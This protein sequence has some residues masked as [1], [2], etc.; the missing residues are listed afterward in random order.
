MSD[1]K[2]EVAIHDLKRSKKDT[3][4]RY[5]EILR[6]LSAKERELVSALHIK[7]GVNPVTIASKRKRG[8]SQATVFVIMSDWHME[9]TV[10]RVSVNGLNAFN[11]RIAEERAMAV[12][13]N[14]VRLAEIVQKDIAVDKMVLA[15]IGDFISGNIHE[16]LLENCSLSPIDATIFAQ[17]IIAGGIKHIL[18]K[19]KL[20]IEV[21]TAAGNHAR[22]TK[23]T[24]F[25][26]ENGN[27]L[28]YM[29]Y[30]SLALHFARE[31]RV[32]FHISQGYHSFVCCYGRNIRFHHGHA[33]KYGGGIGGLTIPANKAIAQWNKGMPKKLV[34]DLDVFGH[35][36]TFIDA[37][38]FICN[39]SLIGYNAFAKAIK[40]SYEE[41]CQAFFVIDRD[42]GKTFVCPI[43]TW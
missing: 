20:D 28:E 31:K 37:G 9:E 25:S 23:Q 21:I 2:H 38:S 10:K 34:A 5:R 11:L 26:T 27:S 6:A 14:C 19:T 24:H 1:I 43:L 22:I 16:E 40:A 39:G 33:V 3:D 42:R 35:F 17:G 18:E 12:F 13:R 8:N 41:P 36:H 32:R 15:L 7:D 29:M 30:H 4:K